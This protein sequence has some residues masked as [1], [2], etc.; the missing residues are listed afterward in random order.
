[1]FPNA[2]QLKFAFVA[3]CVLASF[4]YGKRVCDTRDA[5][6]LRI[7]M[8]LTVCADFCLLILYQNIPG[9]LFFCCVQCA[10]T[11]RY[12]GYRRAALLLAVWAVLFPMF[13]IML[14]FQTAVSAVYAVSF[15]F[16]LFSAAEAFAKKIY[17]FPNGILALLGMCLF[18]ICDINV[19]MYNTHI[20][21]FDARAAVIFT[22]MW[23]AYLPAQ[24]MLSA[25][26]F[27]YRFAARK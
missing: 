6:Y 3:L 4:S 12:G 13:I 11:A 21:F 26:G 23:A 2:D 15:A 16:S 14:P 22:V 1:M 20:P 5:F 9:I 18:A 24:A 25:S 8:C 7:A 17:P 10:Y 27:G 19:A